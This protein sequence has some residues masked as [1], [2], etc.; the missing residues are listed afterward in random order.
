MTLHS[1]I[2][3]A[4]GA[5]GF[6]FLGMVFLRYDPFSAPTQRARTIGVICAATLFA[7]TL[8]LIFDRIGEMPL[9]IAVFSGCGLVAGVVSMFL[10][11][12][13]LSAPS[14]QPDG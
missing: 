2:A 3:L 5:V 8:V 10:A 4:T 6:L 12:R 9:W 11:R 7:G 13:P 14:D 1:V